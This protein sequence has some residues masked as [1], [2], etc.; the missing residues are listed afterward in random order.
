[1]RIIGDC[2]SGGSF[3]CRSVVTLALGSARVKPSRASSGR[4]S[5]VSGVG[6]A[7]GGSYSQRLKRPPWVLWRL[8]AIADADRLRSAGT[9]I[10]SSARARSKSGTGSSA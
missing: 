1:M 2:K 8:A 3:R 6:A 7:G 10:P 9:A 5:A 4:M